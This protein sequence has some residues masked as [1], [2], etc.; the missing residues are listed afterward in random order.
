[1]FTGLLWQNADPTTNLPYSYDFAQRLLPGDTISTVTWNLEV[2]PDVVYTNI[3][4]NTPTSH[5]GT[6][7]TNGSVVTNWLSGLVA[8]T[9]YRLTATITAAPSGMIDDLFSYLRVD[10]AP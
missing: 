9:R 7:T 4:D 1:M 2:V 8:N 10:P 5:L 6:P 3:A